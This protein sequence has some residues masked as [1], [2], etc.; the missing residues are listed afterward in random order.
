MG[1]K[2]MKMKVKFDDG[3]EME[4]EGK[5]VG[6]EFYIGEKAGYYFMHPKRAHEL[7]I[8]NK[9]TMEYAYRRG[10]MCLMYA[11][12]LHHNRKREYDKFIGLVKGYSIEG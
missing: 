10:F 4:Y 1:G 6:N 9:D 11:N 12:S 8:I 2:K 7:E 3:G 5:K